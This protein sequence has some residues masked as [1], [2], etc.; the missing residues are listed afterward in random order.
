MLAPVERYGQP[1]HDAPWSLTLH[2]LEKAGEADVRLDPVEHRERPRQRA[3]LVGDRHTRAHG[4]VIERQDP[5]SG[6]EQLADSDATSLEAGRDAVDRWTAA[7]G[8]GRPAAPFAVHG[9]HHGAKHVLSVQPAAHGCVG[10]RD[11]GR[12]TAVHC[13][14]EQ[15]HRIGAPRTQLVGEH[16]QLVGGVH[17]RRGDHHAQAAGL[18]CLLEQIAHQ[19]ATFAALRCLE[20]LLQLAHLYAELV[21]SGGHAVRLHPERRGHMV[22]RALKLTVVFDGS[23]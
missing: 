19:V 5:H 15:E 22:P 6:P 9:G 13:R 2:K 21:D 16:Q 20:L 12:G 18:E 23:S 7:A 11:H 1:Y 10:G 14:H 17:L 8:K 3:R 4:A